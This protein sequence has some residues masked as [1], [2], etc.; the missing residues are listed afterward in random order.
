LST[1]DFGGKLI[2][3]EATEGSPMEIVSLGP[4]FAAELRGVTLAEIAAEDATYKETRAAF[5]EHSV[6][7]FR[8]QNVSDEAQLAFSSRFGPLTGAGLGAVG[9][10]HPPAGRRD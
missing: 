6:L 1:A 8:G 10:R 5:E 2:K 9:A 4:G 7:V 3:T